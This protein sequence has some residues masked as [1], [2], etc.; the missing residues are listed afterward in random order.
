MKTIVEGYF[1]LLKVLIVLCLVS[2]VVLVFGNVVLR[3]GFNSGVVFSEEVSRM[4]F[5]YV[6][7]LGSIVAL[8]EHM[9]LGVDSLVAR[10]PMRLRRIFLA[11]SHILVLY[12]IWLLLKGS[13]EQAVINIDTKTPVTGISMAVFYGVGVVFG[14][15][16]GAML[17][18]NLLRLLCGRMS[19]REVMQHAQIVDP[20]LDVKTIRSGQPSKSEESDSVHVSHQPVLG[21]AK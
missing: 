10:C 8:R 2:M 18:C 17:S 4:L 21:N 7:F 1:H 5:V 20:A 14:L 16:T 13:W 3:Y 15:S 6:T 11:I 12:V 19:D 9:H